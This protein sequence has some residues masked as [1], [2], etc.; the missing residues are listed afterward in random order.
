MNLYRYRV[1]ER[2]TTLES[3]GKTRSFTWH[4][5]QRSVLG[6]MWTDIASFGHDYDAIAAYNTKV[7]KEKNK[8]RVIH[9]TKQSK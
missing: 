6:I 8:D 7:T 1:V 3:D 2:T 5:L 9:P 4:Y